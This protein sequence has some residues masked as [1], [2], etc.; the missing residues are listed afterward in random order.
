MHQLR[1]FQ[2]RVRRKTVAEREKRPSE[3]TDEHWLWAMPV[4]RKQNEDDSDLIGKWMVFA[5]RD[6]V[7]LV[8]EKLSDAVRSG[9]LSNCTIATKVS[10]AARSTNP[11]FAI[12]IYTSDYRDKKV[13]A[14]CLSAIRQLGITGHL[15]YK[16]DAQTLA[17]VY[18]GGTKRPWIY[19]SDM[20]EAAKEGPSK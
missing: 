10:T 20:F 5:S 15:Y 9:I 6:S 4:Q 16:T 7:D 12:M 13:V 1:L 17:G 11:S 8:W 3:V 2:V 19:N 14:S 18:A